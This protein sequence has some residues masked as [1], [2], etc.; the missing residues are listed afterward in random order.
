VTG[1]HWHITSATKHL[2]QFHPTT[3]SSGKSSHRNALMNF[4]GFGGLADRA[5]YA[6]SSATVLSITR[7]VNTP[8]APV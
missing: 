8:I 2:R 6:V 1:C 5:T 4:F 7:H 3:D